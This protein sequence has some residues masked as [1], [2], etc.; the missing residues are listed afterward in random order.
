MAGRWVSTPEAGKSQ[1]RVYDV[2]KSASARPYLNESFYLGF[3][4]SSVSG[5]VVEDTLDIGNGNLLLENFSFGVVYQESSGIVNQ[6][7]DGF[8]GLGFSGSSPNS[9]VPFDLWF[10]QLS[11]SSPCSVS[12][13]KE[14]STKH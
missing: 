9:K 8:L 5:I 1:G 14:N 12:I 2:E 10:F 4:Q 3:P 7:F 13:S 6:P 11:C